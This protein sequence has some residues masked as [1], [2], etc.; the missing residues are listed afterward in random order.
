MIITI[1]TVLNNVEA[2]QIPPAPGA[3]LPPHLQWLYGNQQPVNDFGYGKGAGPKS[4]TVVGA[5]QN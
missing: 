3:I 4:I 1:I 2:F 5:T